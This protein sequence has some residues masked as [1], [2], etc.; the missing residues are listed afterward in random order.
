MILMKA[1]V[2]SPICP[3]MLRPSHQCERADEALFGM[4]LEVLEN[5]GGGWHLVRAP[6]RYEGYA[7]ED[8]LLFG[9]GNARRWAVAPKRVVLKGICDV[10]AAPLVQSWALATLTQGALVS[11]VGEPKEGGWQKVSLPDGREGYTKSS[12]LG[13]YYKKPASADENTLRERLAAAALS[14]L[15]THYRW[16]AKTPMGIDCS[17]LTAMSYLLNGVTIYR[18]AH[19]KEGFPLHEIPFEQLKKG[20]LIFFPG[21]VALYLGEGKYIHSTAYNGSDGVVINSLNPDDPDYRSDLP[22]KI[23]ACGSIF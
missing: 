4:E 14:Y 2:T 8:C 21:H 6:Y 3:L 16:G 22:E 19:I 18:D 7:H 17:G 11:P 1:V 12:F 9:E 13:E 20:D 23:T 10:Q 5:C 15:G